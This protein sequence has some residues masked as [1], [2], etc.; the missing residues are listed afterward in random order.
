MLVY[1][2]EVINMREYYSKLYISGRDLSTHGEEW[3]R[4]SVFLLFTSAL[5]VN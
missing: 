2:T 3:Q 1:C 4:Q 5:M